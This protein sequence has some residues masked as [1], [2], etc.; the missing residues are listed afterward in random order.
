[1]P[2]PGGP[3]RVRPGRAAEVPGRRLQ[4]IQ[5]GGGIVQAVDVIEA[6]AADHA[7]GDEPEQQSVR[8]REHLGI[9]HPQAGESVDVEEPPVVDL[10]EGGT[11][12]RQ[13][14]GL[15]FEQA[16]QAVEAVRVPRCAVE[17]AHAGLDVVADAR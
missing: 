13:A 16:V 8:R 4:P 15:A 14:V 11:P 12:V 1:M 10:V 2:G 7:L 3:L 5:V 6:Q 9:L 17:R